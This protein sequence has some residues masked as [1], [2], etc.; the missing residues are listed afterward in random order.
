[1]PSPMPYLKCP[2]CSLT[3]TESAARSPF[4]NCPR[5][6]LRHGVAEPMAVVRSPGR[7]TTEAKLAHVAA[8]KARL[9]G[10]APGGRSA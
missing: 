7:S 5:C 2:T 10:R 6:L 9:S 4:Q 3:V 8:A 1:M